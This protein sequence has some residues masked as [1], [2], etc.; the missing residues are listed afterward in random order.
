MGL[1]KWFVAGWPAEV[2]FGAAIDKG[3]ESK[4]AACHGPH[5]GPVHFGL[6][7][8]FMGRL[9]IIVSIDDLDEAALT[10][11]LWKPKNALTKQYKRLFDLE[12]VKLR[13]TDDALAA[14][15]KIAHT[16]KTGARGLRSIIE[17]LMLDV[18]YDLPSTEGVTECVWSRARRSSRVSPPQLIR[19]KKAS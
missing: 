7:P 18:M 6:I 8:E 13:F 5:R 10:Q 2:G 19:A 17:E 11:I 16:R 4:D 3:E 15:A 9:P 14:M 1:R 12:D